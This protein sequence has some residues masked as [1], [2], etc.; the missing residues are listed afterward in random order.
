MVRLGEGPRLTKEIPDLPEETGPSRK[1]NSDEHNAV[2]RQV[3]AVERVR[4]TSNA[5]GTR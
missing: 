5:T 2:R 1:S 4:D 3:E